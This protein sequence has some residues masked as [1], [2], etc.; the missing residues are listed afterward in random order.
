MMQISSVNVGQAQVIANAGKSGKT[1]IY[2]QP[3]DQPVTVTALG[4]VNDAVLDTK[5]H[6][7]VDQA[8][9]LYGTPDYAWWS[10]SLGSEL[11]PGT[12]GENLTI[13][14]LE[15]A[16]LRIGDRLYFATVILEVTAPRLPCSTL[17]ARMGDPHFVKRF[18]AAERPGAYC[19]VIQTG[20]IR[21]G[22]AVRL[23]PFTGDPLTVLDLFRFSYEKD[24]SEAT[25]EQILAAP[26]DIRGRRDYEKKLAE[27]KQ[28]RDGSLTNS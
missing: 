2:K 5:H 19:R 8:V 1:G 24:L 12:F 11:A 9:Y 22:E 4:L 14:E 17:A 16:P 23:E 3:T 10:Q 25:L 7:G 28:T 13:T 26:V 27:L 6:G 18:R 15:S 20:A 21:Q